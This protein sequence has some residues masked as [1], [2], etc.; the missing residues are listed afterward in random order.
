[1]TAAEQRATAIIEELDRGLDTGNEAEIQQAKQDLERV[2][3]AETP[4]VRDLLAK[5]LKEK[6]GH[7]RLQM[8]KK[9]VEVSAIEQVADLIESTPGVENVGDLM[10]KAH[11]EGD[12]YTMQLLRRAFG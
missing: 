9:R 4:E 10:D 5:M 1:M 3:A 7:A 2:A 12:V 6:A 8:V 11:R